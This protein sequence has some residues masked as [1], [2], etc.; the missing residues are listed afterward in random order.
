[1]CGELGD[2]GKPGVKETGNA[3]EDWKGGARSGT[4]KVAAYALEKRKSY[5]SIWQ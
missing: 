1:M 4:S 5:R 2:G 3:I